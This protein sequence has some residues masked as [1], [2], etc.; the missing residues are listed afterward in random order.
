MHARKACKITMLRIVLKTAKS[1]S[2]LLMAIYVN[3]EKRDPHLLMFAI[4]MLAEVETKNICPF[5]RMTKFGSTYLYN[6]NNPILAS[7]LYADQLLIMN[8]KDH[9]SVTSAVKRSQV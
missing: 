3:F 8:H 1:R 2:C 5:N 7:Q 6:N 4:C 9:I